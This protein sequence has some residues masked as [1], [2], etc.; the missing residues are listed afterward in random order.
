MFVANRQGEAPLSPEVLAV[1]YQLTPA[2]ARLAALLAGGAELKDIAGTLGVSLNTARSQLRSVFAKT[3]TRRQS[4]LIH[5]I[6]T[7]PARFRQE[8]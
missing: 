5:R 7:S 3:G 8:I 6:L 1:L 2:E 4:E